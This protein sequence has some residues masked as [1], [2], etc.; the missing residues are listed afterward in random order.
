MR[1]SCFSVMILRAGTVGLVAVVLG[2]LGCSDDDCTCAGAGGTSAVAGSAGEGGAAGASEAMGGTDAGGSTGTE[3]E[4]GFLTFTHEEQPVGLYVPED[5]EGPLPVVLFL[6]S[7]GNS[8]I[9]ETFWIIDA[10]NA[11]EP[12]AVLLPSRPAEESTECAAWGGTYDA[13]MRPGL[14][15]AL[16]ALDLVIEE[17]GF[18]TSRQY[19][20][21]E[22]MGGEGV[23]RLLVD[24]PE[25]FAGA[26]A[27]AGY[28]LDTGA[29]E[30]AKTP[31]TILHGSL[32]SISPVSSSRT[33]Y[34]SILDAGGTKVQYLEY[35]G[36]D[37]VPAI[38]AARVEPDLL[39]W[40]MAARRE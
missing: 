15:D 34:Q 37:H 38:E 33:I 4:R 32:D 2:L 3:L 36:L 10:L 9:F 29:T 31:L 39:P 8:P 35:E 27:V 25:R 17:Y 19:L 13:T 22:S 7:C 14:A 40:L 26:V 20:Y 24:R 28:T 18:D 5:A 23:F 6:H 16:T 1:L 11:I 12:T 21:G 30:M